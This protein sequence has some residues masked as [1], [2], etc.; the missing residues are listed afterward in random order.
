MLRPTRSRPVTKTDIIAAVRLCNLIKTK[1][2]A[3]Q[4]VGNFVFARWEAAGD[5][6]TLGPLPRLRGGAGF[7]RECCRRM[8]QL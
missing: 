7:L 4:I 8:P 6:L 5:W 3:V 2:F 1:S